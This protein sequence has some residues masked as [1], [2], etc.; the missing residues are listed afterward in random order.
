MFRAAHVSASTIK[1]IK[2]VIIFT[3]K[4][5][6]VVT[7]GR[8]RRLWLGGAHRGFLGVNSVVS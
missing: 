6:V 2:E 4:V 5:R 8:G 3:I 7:L 1:K